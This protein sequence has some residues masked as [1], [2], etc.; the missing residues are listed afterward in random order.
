MKPFPR[1][2]LALPVLLVLTACGN[3]YQPGDFTRD[4]RQALQ[5]HP[6]AP[7][8]QAWVERFTQAYGDFTSPKLGA[9][10]R[11][12]Y[13]SKLF[14]NDTVHTHHRRSELIAYLQDTSERLDDMALEI[15]DSRIAGHDLYL[16]WVMRTDFRAGFREVSAETIG[17]SHLRFNEDGKV[18]LHQDFW[19]SR[20]G[21][22]EH[23]PVVGGLIEWIRSG[24]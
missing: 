3:S 11:E 8:Q 13:A 5:E 20:Q 21:I 10:M 1:M 19:D 18:I 4:Y 24:L 12:L 14:F 7:V 17:M 2:L 22:F 15:L 6:G 23:I 16:R 9:R